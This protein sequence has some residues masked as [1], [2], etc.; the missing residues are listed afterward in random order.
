MSAPSSVE[1]KGLYRFWWVWTEPFRLLVRL[2][3]ERWVRRSTWMLVFSTARL[4]GHLAMGHLW[5]TVGLVLVLFTSA[6]FRSTVVGLLVLEATLVL[7]RAKNGH[8]SRATLWRLA[9]KFHRQWPRVFADIAAKTM[10]IQ[11]FDGSGRGESRAAAIRPVVDHPRMPWRFW[12]QW[13]VVTFRVGV[14]PGRTF[15]EFE[16]VVSAMAANMPWVHAVELE[17]RTDRSSFGL[18]HVALADILAASKRPTWRSTRSDPG[19]PRLRLVDPDTG[20]VA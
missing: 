19:R 1:P 14:A 12:L 17:Y 20:E 15:A 16:K 18:L 9:W 6:D 13:P 8:P 11:G 10:Q 3:V 2:V 7:A 4:V 5:W